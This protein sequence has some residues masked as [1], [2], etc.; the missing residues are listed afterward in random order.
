MRPIADLL[1]DLNDAA[2]VRKDPFGLAKEIAVRCNE[3]LGNPEIRDLVIAAMQHADLFSSLDG[4]LDS[5]AHRVGLHP[6]AQAS[7]LSTFERFNLEAHRPLDFRIDGRAVVFHRDQAAVYRALMD[8]ASLVLSA[9][10]SFGKSLVIDALLASQRFNK[11]LIIVPTI[12]LVDETRRRMSAFSTTHKIIT[13]PDQPASAR[14]IFVMTQERA[15]ERTDILSLDL[16]IV[17]EFYK[18]DPPDAGDERASALNHAFYKYRKIAR[19]SYLL[20]PNIE[21]L[22]GEVATLS[23]LKFRKSAFNTVI[24][25]LIPVKGR[26]KGKKAAFLNL[27]QSLTDPTLVYCKSPNQANSV[28][29]DLINSDAV[30]EIPA[31]T[32]AADWIGDTFHPD[33]SLC[34]GL[35]RGVGLHHGQMPRSVAQLMV[36]LFNDGLIKFLICTSS[37]IEGV[38][39]SAKNVI[40]YSDR[41]GNKQL[42]HFTFKNIQG[43]AG[44][45][46][47]HFKGHVYIFDKPP[48]P[49][50][51]VVDIPSI[52]QDNDTPLGLLVQLD[53]QDL[54]SGAAQRVDTLL[55]HPLIRSGGLSFGTLKANSHIEPMDQ[56]RLAEEIRRN[57]AR[58]HPLLS[59]HGPKPDWQ[60]LKATYDHYCPA[61]CRIDSTGC[62]WPVR[63]SVEP[64]MKG[65]AEW[66]F[67]RTG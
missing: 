33:W 37:L 19:Q 11:I 20:G 5:L 27:A 61:N 46:K 66:A 6:Y 10:T 26:S 38:N 65:P 12:A 15:I 48:E 32:S 25:K 41:I 43:R 34:N 35:R 13:H 31:L 44:R 4:V 30:V 55:Q 40:V 67:S 17:D 42:D 23:G 50:S 21:G 62:R 59:W 3:D 47:R 2:S 63:R 7:K 49:E 29:R 58:L 1:A 45:M 52:T 28:L 14:S 24:S 16:L 9:P 60:S 36:S 57:V 54:N 8:G 18:L 53:R 51:A 64:R 22:A 39:T 56:L